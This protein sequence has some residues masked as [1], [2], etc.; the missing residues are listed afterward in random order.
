MRAERS[1]VRRV[2]IVAAAL[3]A[4]CAVGMGLGYGG[5]SALSVLLGVAIGLGNLWALAELVGWLLDR[6]PGGQKARA[7]ILM[8]V[9]TAAL[10]ALVG[11]LLSRPWV[12]GG[13]FMAGLT[14]VAVSIALGGLWGSSDSEE[15]SG[16]DAGKT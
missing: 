1:L 11:V 4:L 9:K 6:K 14:V 10:F 7:A 16:D 8:V 13:S 3:G 15:G 2:A 12:R 5:L